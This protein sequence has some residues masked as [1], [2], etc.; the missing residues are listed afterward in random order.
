M[1]LCGFLLACV[2]SFVLGMFINMHIIMTRL[3]SLLNRARFDL[4]HGWPEAAVDALGRAL[5]LLEGRKTPQNV[6]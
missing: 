5:R 6:D 1:T 4:E 2:G 3:R